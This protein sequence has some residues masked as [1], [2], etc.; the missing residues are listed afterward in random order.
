VHL[1]GDGIMEDGA[2]FSD[3]GTHLYPFL[4]N[5]F[6][7]DLSAP[8]YKAMANSAAYTFGLLPLAPWAH[9]GRVY[10][11]DLLCTD[12]ADVLKP[13]VSTSNA[14]AT[15]EYQHLGPG[16]WTA[17]VYR[18]TSTGQDYRTLL[19]G[20]DLAHLRATYANVAQIGVTPGNDFARTYWLA[21]VLNNH[22]QV[23][24]HRPMVDIGDLPGI[25]PER[26]AN[27][28]LGSFP[29]PSF[30]GR[31]VTL[32]FS[33]ARAQAVT[34]RIYDVAGREVARLSAKGVEGSN[35]ATW[36]GTLANGARAAAG[37]YFYA[38]EGV[39]VSREARTSKMILLSSR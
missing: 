26:F 31:A 38:L 21:D 4:T 29:N 2:L 35:V 5:L 11:L 15:A 3:D 13:L 27:A 18:P 10:G 7:A 32:R 14:V 20:F 22:F 6:G 9:P 12:E 8:N 34:L 23:C 33:L 25:A 28:N 37:V 36:D 24:A 30:A 39:D 16:P 19:D 17:S 1:S